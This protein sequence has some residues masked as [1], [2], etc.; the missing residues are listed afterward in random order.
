VWNELEKKYSLD[1]SVSQPELLHDPPKKFPRSAT[2]D[3][4]HLQTFLKASFTLLSTKKLYNRHAHDPFEILHDPLLDR[5]LSVEKRCP[6]AGMGN[7]L[8][9]VGHIRNKLAIC[10]PVHIQK[11][12]KIKEKFYSFFRFYFKAMTKSIFSRY[13]T[14]FKNL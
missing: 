4:H 3:F 11:K 7:S 2:E 14:C 8:S 13:L 6:R 9:L 10:G 5:E 1:F 12:I